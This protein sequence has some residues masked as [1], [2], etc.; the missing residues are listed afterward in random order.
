MA[1][2]QGVINKRIPAA[3]ILAPALI[4]AAAFILGG[5]YP[6]GNS[7]LLSEGTW[8]K[9]IESF[10]WFRGLFSGANDF[11]YNF[12]Q[13]LGDGTASFWGLQFLSP[14]NYLLF[15]IPAK[16]V[17]LGVLALNGIRTA[18]SAAAFYSLALNITDDKKL[19]FIGSLM[20]S[21]AG[22]VLALYWQSMWLDSLWI[23][24]LFMSGLMLSIMTGSGKKLVLSV[25]L[26]GICCPAAGIIFIP[27]CLIIFGFSGALSP[28]NDKSLASK[29]VKTVAFA[30][31][32]M[33]LSAFC[34]FPLF[35][36]M[37]KGGALSVSLALPDNPSAALGALLLPLSLTA[38]C[39]LLRGV[40]F[41][42]KLSVS[43]ALPVLIF[44]FFVRIDFSAFGI[45]PELCQ[46]ILAGGVLIFIFLRFAGL[47]RGASKASVLAFSGINAALFSLFAVLSWADV[48][49]A[50]RV[51]LISA[52]ALTSLIPVVLLALPKAPASEKLKKSKKPQKS[53]KPAEAYPQI[54][55]VSRALSGAFMAILIA[56]PV[57]WGI[58]EAFNG[59]ELPFY[60]PENFNSK[61]KAVREISGL[62]H[63]LFRMET[64]D[65]EFA[66]DSW[67]YSYSGITGESGFWLNGY[68]SVPAVDSLFGVKYV[69]SPAGKRQR[70]YKEW[71]TSEDHT[72]WVNP[73]VLPL[74]FLAKDKIM[75]ATVDAEAPFTAVNR[76]Y[77]SAADLQRNV[78]Q[79]I[80]LLFRT[81]K[82]E[83]DPS[84]IYRFIKNDSGED[85]W[86]EFTYR[87]K[88]E[89][90]VYM[91]IP[92]ADPDDV[93]IIMN[94]EAISYEKGWII[95][96]KVYKKDEPFSFRV[97]LKGNEAAIGEPQ[98]VYENL[99]ALQEYTVLLRSYS[100]EL[101]RESASSIVGYADVPRGGRYM[102]TTI[103][104]DSDWSVKIDGERAE[105]VRSVGGLLSVYLEEGVHT[106]TFRYMPAEYLTGM[107]ISLAVLV[108]MLL[109]LRLIKMQKSQEFACEPESQDK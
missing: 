51:F 47:L 71:F 24:P 5:V 78:F 106:V 7:C 33:G 10:S 76:I 68:A 9:L 102:M 108:L 66:G 63:T 18:L 74:G 70:S 85:V 81:G 4:F 39:F 107:E 32:G 1:S 61:Y 90:F 37:I 84:G 26:M 16:A 97:K 35:S 21:S 43:G 45:M 60:F 82:L 65:K 75:R 53:K 109:I 15:L 23:L 58:L 54:K 3:V 40:S 92:Y 101:I 44:S 8:L 13:G 36:R 42:E 77:M 98:V 57:V 22:I 25:L 86:M 27:A 20:Y 99:G 29:L 12:S 62:D 88:T 59:G 93:D 41:K 19:S 96:L 28:E 14:L 83:K 2:K 67:L 17:A 80:D 49:A 6:M 50:Q 104:Y 105:P 69:V 91:Y 30:A 89:A 79:P 46:G 64:T 72:V 34:W 38:L 55:N 31:G 103:P 73:F 94:G 52:G 11:L 56:S 100:C 95:P 87:A 48:N